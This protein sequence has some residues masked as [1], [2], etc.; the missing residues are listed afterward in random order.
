MCVRKSKLKVLF[1][2]GLSYSDHTIRES[3]SAKMR[4]RLLIR[5]MPKK[6]LLHSMSLKKGNNFSTQRLLKKGCFSE[7]PDSHAYPTKV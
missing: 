5:M 1:S 2:N 6:G 4:K 3:K 7:V